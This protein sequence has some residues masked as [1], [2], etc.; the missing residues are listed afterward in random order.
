MNQT[1][2]LI[3]QL[4]ELMLQPARPRQQAE[5]QKQI[6]RLRR[7]VPAGLLRAFDHLVL[8]GRIPVAPVSQSGA[9]R[10]CHL[11]LPP[12]DVLSLRRAAEQLHNCPYCGCF[13]YAAPDPALTENRLAA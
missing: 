12:G 3:I 2:A 8:H 13:I 1:L 10:S 9:C 5:R 4:H 11:N 7:K 6:D